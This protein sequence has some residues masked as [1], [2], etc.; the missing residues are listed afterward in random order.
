VL[1]K[2]SSVLFA[3]ELSRVAPVRALK[4]TMDPAVSPGMK[5]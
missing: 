4:N 2:S 1:E 5:C 3:L